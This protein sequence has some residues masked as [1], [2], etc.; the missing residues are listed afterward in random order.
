M[1]ER[2]REREREKEKEREREREI[3]ASEK[4]WG[5][6]QLKGWVILHPCRRDFFC[7][8]LFFP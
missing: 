5:E 1:R 4:S 6:G 3:R 8:F 2:E 7:P